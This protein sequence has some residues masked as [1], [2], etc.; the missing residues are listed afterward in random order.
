ML[1][2]LNSFIGR[3]FYTSIFFVYYVCFKSYTSEACD[4]ISRVEDVYNYTATQE[5]Q[6][7]KSIGQ[8]T[9]LSLNKGCYCY[10]FEQV[11][12]VPIKNITDYSKN[13][14]DP[15]QHVNTKTLLSDYY[16]IGRKLELGI[17][18]D[19]TLLDKAETKLKNH[20]VNYYRYQGHPYPNFRWVL[21][22]RDYLPRN[23]SHEI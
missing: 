3:A 6:F 4:L 15:I 2:F 12:G 21:W 22:A 19:N 23:G 17:C 5:Q 8:S 14:P 13:I 16:T 1:V 9:P 11:L 18:R 10:A 20:L 7:Y